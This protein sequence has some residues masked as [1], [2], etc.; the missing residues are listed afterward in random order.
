MTEVRDRDRRSERARLIEV[1]G[2]ESASA[3]LS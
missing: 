3:L 2:M 1:P